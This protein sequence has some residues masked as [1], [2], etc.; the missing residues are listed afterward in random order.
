MVKSA[1]AF[2]VVACLAVVP[3]AA[4]AQ[5]S[6]I[7]GIVKDTSGAVLPGV[8]VEAASPVLI[9]KVRSAV[10][11]G[12]G[13]Y[14]ILELRPGTYTVTFT[15]T[16]FSTLRREGLELPAD[17]VSTV[18][19]DM[20]V[21]ALEETVTVTGESPIVDRPE[22]AAAADAEYRADR[23]ASHRAGIRGPHPP[24][25]VDDRLGRRQQQRP[26]DH[27]DDRLRR[28]RRAWERRGCPDGRDRHRGGDQ[29]RRRLGLR[30]ARHAEEVVFTSTG[31]LGEAE[32]GGPIVN[33]VP[34]T[35]GNTFQ[36]R[37]Q[38]S[39]MTGAMQSSNYTQALR[40]AGLTTPASHELSV[41]HE[42]LERR[43]DQEGSALVLLLDAVPGRMGTMSS[44]C[45][46]TRTPAT[47]P[48]GP[49]SRT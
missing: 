27:R 43:A 7:T 41:G 29:R 40:D 28:P 18:N 13:Q 35:G 30:A 23:G 15:L 19:I 20:R 1:S 44:A 4:Y 14:R 34:R 33:L 22:R 2:V 31:G 21:G 39:G 8:T 24:D 11:D 9:E 37:F 38:G 36:H 45:S 6:S 17:F 10:T 42:P 49:T 25:A 47:R 32:V 3:T 46:T 26:A 12:A 48:S 16:G 5:G